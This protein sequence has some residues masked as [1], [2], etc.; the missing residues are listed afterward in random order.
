M[1]LPAGSLCRELLQMRAA[2]KVFPA[3]PIAI[4]G[5]HGRKAQSIICQVGAAPVN[6]RDEEAT[7]TQQTFTGCSTRIKMSL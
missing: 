5:L 1:L 4:V 2:G 7:Y 3:N 6:S